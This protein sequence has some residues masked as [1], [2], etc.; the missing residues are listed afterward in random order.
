MLRKIRGIGRL[1]T[2]QS[3]HPLADP[4][5]SRKILGE[6]PK[7]DA[8]R[9]LDE[10]AGWLESVNG[11]DEFPATRLFEVTQEL[12]KLAHPHLKRLSREYL[13]SVSMSR[14]D[15]KRLWS[16]N[17][18]FW[19]LLAA[20]YERC[21]GAV[22][23]HPK[24]GGLA[25]TVLPLL[26][27]R[28]IGAL[29]SMLKWQ[30]FHYGPTPDE[31]WRRLGLA[32][33]AAEAAGGDGKSVPA[34]ARG[35]M[36][37]PML[38]YQKVMILRVASLDAMLPVEIE[39]AERFVAHFLSGFIFTRDALPDSVYW[40][41]LA[42]PQPPL[43]LAQMPESATP[44]LRFLK[45]GTAQSG[46]RALLE[47][48]E[49]G[50]ELPP[51][52]DL[53]QAYPAKLLVRVLRHLCTYLAPIP[54]QRQHRRHRVL[55]HMSVVHGLANAFTVFSGEFSGSPAA[56]PVENWQV[57]NVSR[58]GFGAV[59]GHASG[60]WLQVGALI[61]MQ[62]EGGENWL[63]GAVRRH[64]REPAGNARVGIEALARK[65]ATVELRPRSASS[66]A[67]A[68]AVHALILLDGEGTADT[69]VIL[70][71]L[72]FDLRES[73]EFADAGVR[74]LLTPVGLLEQTADYELARYRQSRLA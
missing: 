61:A 36:T 17:H 21:L 29:G 40:A 35:G 38:E 5:E 47:R 46:M 3:E 68:A 52:I 11:V 9:G 49:L 71:P 26:C 32:L 73:M 31:V 7:D 64:R 53:G 54:P 74:Y 24:S 45:P 43:R 41:D 16:I 18:G 58:G 65:V 30:Q 62:P 13:V 34:L 39:I 8:F 1:F 51:D 2:P 12:E 56:L 23:D 66:Y 72:T 55:H 57:E 50:G 27:S 28:L 33:L 22:G 20:S 15:E 37:S 48:L 44:T 59:I 14:P 25:K 19:T 10:I 69:L 63:L 6:L 60:E 67:A 4:R 42:L 70:P